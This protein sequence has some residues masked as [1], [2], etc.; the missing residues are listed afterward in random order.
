MAFQKLIKTDPQIYEF[1]KPWTEPN[2]YDINI[3]PPIV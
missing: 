1:I 3:Q 2:D